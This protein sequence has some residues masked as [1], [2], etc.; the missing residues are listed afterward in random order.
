MGLRGLDQLRRAIS[1]ER[2][3]A[4][5]TPTSVARAGKACL[6]AGSEAAMLEYLKEYMPDSWN[7]NDIRKIRFGEIMRGMELGGSYAFDK[8][9]YGRYYVQVH[10]VGL[11]TMEAD[12]DEANA[13]G[14]KFLMVE[15]ARS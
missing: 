9:S 1:H 14:H 8:E 6:V 11:T 7:R 13:N 5:T 15:T 2:L 12:F 10:K 3:D 4:Y